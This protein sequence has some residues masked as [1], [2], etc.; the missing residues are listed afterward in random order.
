MGDQERK[1]RAAR[2]ARLRRRLEAGPLDALALAAIMKGILD[3]L[4][5]EL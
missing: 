2:I 3:L 4:D 5:D 1:S